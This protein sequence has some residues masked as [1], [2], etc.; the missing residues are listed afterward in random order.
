MNQIYFGDNLE[1]L[2]SLPSASV[3]LDL[4]RPAVQHRQGAGAHPAQDRE[5]SQRRP[6][7]LCGAALHHHQDR[8]Q[9][10]R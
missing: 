10:V 6:H 3:E 8:L 5:V 2:R 7:R 1:I 4:Y 9:G